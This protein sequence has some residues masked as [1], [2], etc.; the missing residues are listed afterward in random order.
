MFYVVP[1]HKKV[2][3]VSVLRNWSIIDRQTQS[4]NS[5]Q[6]EPRSTLQ[7]TKESSKYK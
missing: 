4:Q 7:G 1:G 5:S 3:L 6:S 2:V